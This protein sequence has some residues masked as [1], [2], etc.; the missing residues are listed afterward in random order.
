MT[1][2][3]IAFIGAIVGGI[4]TLVIAVAKGLISFGGTS[5]ATTQNTEK[6]NDL[7]EKVEGLTAEEDLE[8]LKKRV[9]AIEADIYKL[10]ER[11]SRIEG[12][13]GIYDKN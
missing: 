1:I 3:L 13:I 6:I 10:R 4:I 5:E 11:I 12:K 7:Q 8:E 9:G 2:E